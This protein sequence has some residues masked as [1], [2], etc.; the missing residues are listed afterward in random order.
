M[1]NLCKTMLSSVVV[2]AFCACGGGG[3]EK[4]VSKDNSSTQTSATQDNKTTIQ[5]DTPKSYQELPMAD[6]KP[7]FTNEYLNGKTFYMTFDDGTV[8]EIT[9]SLNEL[10]I[11]KI[12]R[13]LQ[14]IPYTI[15][16][17]GY[18]K[19][20]KPSNK[21]FYI[22]ILKSDDEKLSLISSQNKEELKKLDKANK[23]FYFTKQKAIDFVSGVEKDKN[24]TANFKFTSEWLDDKTLYSVDILD[25]VGKVGVSPIAFTK[26]QIVRPEATIDYTIKDGSLHFYDK[27]R[28]VNMSIKPV[29][30]D[31]E[32]IT[33]YFFAD[34]VK[35]IK[36]WLFYDEQ[37][38]RDFA[39]TL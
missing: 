7:V 3:S 34:G 8:E 23:Y 35:E 10:S 20:T 4:G 22:K 26:T 24:D 39:K 33:F 19:F 1:E 5:S 38:A 29:A 14:Y 21:T 13:S 12:A 32:K 16:K 2:L 15:T 37:K 28:K 17:E 9:F 25:E 30:N 6:K 36:G 31:D 11:K 18:I 27:R